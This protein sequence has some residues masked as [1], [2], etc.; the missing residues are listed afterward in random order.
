MSSRDELED[1]SDHAW[2]KGEGTTGAVGFA[3]VRRREDGRGAGLAVLPFVRGVVGEAVMGNGMGGFEELEPEGSAA[4]ESSLPTFRLLL[5]WAVDSDGP[6]VSLM[7]SRSD[8]VGEAP[9]AGEA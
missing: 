9:K 3:G 2:R 6:L 5:S 1:P 8:F 4:A 7:I